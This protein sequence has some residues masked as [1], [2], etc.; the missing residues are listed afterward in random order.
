MMG[1]GEVLKLIDSLKFTTHNE[2][3]EIS[4]NMGKDSLTKS[5]G[6]LIKHNEIICY[7]ISRQQ[8]YFSIDFYTQIGK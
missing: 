6:K 5:L 4:D 7:R 2:L 3:C 1:Q 8:I